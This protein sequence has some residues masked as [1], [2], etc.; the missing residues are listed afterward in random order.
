MLNCKQTSEDC[1]P[2]K[3]TRYLSLLRSGDDLLCDQAERT[4][5]S[6]H[7]FSGTEKS[8]MGKLDYDGADIS[9]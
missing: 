1:N 9:F 4:G 6:P 5:E 7:A 2:S 3:A 8:R